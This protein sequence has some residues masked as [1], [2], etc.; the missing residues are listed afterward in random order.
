MPKLIEF[1][2]LKKN[3]VI[4]LLIVIILEMGQRMGERF[5]PIY[6][7]AL[8]GGS[9]VVG[10]LNGLNNLLGA[11]Y[12]FP[13]GY[14]S[15]KFG[16]KKSLIIFDIIAMFG[17]AI[18]I[19]F[20]YW[21]AAIIGAIFFLSWSSISLPAIMSAI[22]KI[23]PQ[24]KQ[25]MGVSMHSLVRRIPMAIG[26]VLGGLCIAAFGETHGIRVAFFISFLL[27]FAAIFVQ[28][29]FL[30]DKHEKN[31]TIEKNPFKVLARMNS[32]LKH[33]LVSDILIRFCEQIPY[34]FVVIWCMKN[35]GVSA[36]DFGILTTAEMITAM[37]IY[38]PVAY[39][40]EKNKSKKPYIAITFTFFAI[41]PIILFFSHSFW[42]LF[43]AFI[44]RGLKEFGEPTRKAF[45]LTLA[46][47]NSKAAMYGTY[48]LI[49]DVVVSVAAFAGGFLW[50]ISPATNLICATTFGFIGVIYF[51]VYCKE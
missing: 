35:I 45:I 26:P 23:L 38:I 44:I 41:F 10:L 6:I 51:I 46:D 7:L 33:L 14:L 2:G 49:R 36:V 5:L 18:V 24:N 34:A 21:Q 48:Y 40:V 12:S 15:D 30:D 47:D 39:L 50:L 17:Y 4:I 29:K 9:V 3:L 19:I 32:D 28:Q 31:E 43:F 42:M 16:Y 11:L 22:S 20:P 25:T 8:G 1:L 13:G 37:L 27:A